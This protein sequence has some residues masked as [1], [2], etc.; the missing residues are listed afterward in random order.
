MIYC[1]Y[2]FNNPSLA[3]I[4]IYKPMNR[5]ELDHV[6][7]IGGSLLPHKI[8]P[9]DPVCHRLARHRVRSS[10]GPDG[11]PGPGKHG[12]QLRFSAGRLSA[13]NGRGRR[14]L[15]AM[16]PQ[17]TPRQVDRHPA[18]IRRHGMSRRHADPLDRPLP[19]SRPATNLRRR[20]GRIPP[21][22][23]G[24]GPRHLLSSHACHGSALQPPRTGGLQPKRRFRAR[25]LRQYRGSRTGP[26]G[27]R[28]DCAPSCRIQG[29][30]ADRGAGLPDADAA[31]VPEQGPPLGRTTGTVGAADPRSG[32]FPV[33]HA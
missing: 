16:G 1:P 26:A 30:A 15:S 25:S 28:R 14:R 21:A 31:R 23:D 3:Q 33:H 22:R 5:P 18:V 24:T 4:G 13:G 27:V 8:H 32:G 9:S 11:Q 12:L 2:A 10:D 7:L 29:F 19:I 6:D 20:H 17:G